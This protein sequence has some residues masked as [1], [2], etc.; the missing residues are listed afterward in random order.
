RAAR[1]HVRIL[2]AHT[3]PSGNVDIVSVLPDGTDLQRL[4]TRASFDAC[5]TAAPNGARLSLCSDHSGAFEIWSMDRSGGRLHRS[6]RFVAWAADPD[7]R[8]GPGRN[9]RLLAFTADVGNGYDIHVGNW[10]GKNLRRL[11]ESP[12]A[13]D[14]PAWS[15]DGSLIAFVSDRTGT[16]QMYVM[17]KRGSDVTRLT[18]APS[19]VTEGPD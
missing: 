16:P 17:N 2:Y 5:P 6:T 18:N 14:F 4:T 12:A 13:D 19:G 1:S 10:R 9:K 7:F 15:P 8:T 3:F 11:N